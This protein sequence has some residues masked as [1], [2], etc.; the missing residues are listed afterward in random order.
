M[1]FSFP[2]LAV[3]PGV[4]STYCGA[5]RESYLTRLASLPPWREQGPLGASQCWALRPPA[6]WV[7][8][9][10][11]HATDVS[12]VSLWPKASLLRELEVVSYLLI[13]DSSIT[14]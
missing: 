2:G 8:T 10:A 6:T 4:R 3:P 7:Q 1:G 12:G 13:G 9:E 14:C 11:W 5:A